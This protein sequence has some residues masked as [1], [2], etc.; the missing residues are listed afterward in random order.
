MNVYPVRGGPEQQ[1]DPAQTRKAIQAGIAF[2]PELPPRL[3]QAAER[4]KRRFERRQA[5]IQG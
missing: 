5:Q 4:L 3:R 2:I 1:R